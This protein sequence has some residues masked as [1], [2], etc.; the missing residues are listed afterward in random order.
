LLLVWSQSAAA[1]KCTLGS[2][3]D[4]VMMSSGFLFKKW[5]NAAHQTD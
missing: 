3:S 1:A 5:H 4:I 2:A